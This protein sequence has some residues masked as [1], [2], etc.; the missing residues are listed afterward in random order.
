MISSIDEEK[1]LNNSANYWLKKT[2]DND[3]VLVKSVALN[4]DMDVILPLK[5]Q[6][7]KNLRHFKMWDVTNMSYT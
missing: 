4:Y 1:A 6:L 5:A 3:R 2:E 7:S